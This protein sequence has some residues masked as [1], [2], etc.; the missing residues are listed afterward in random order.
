MAPK[1]TPHSYGNP[2]R[3]QAARYML[4]TTPKILALVHALHE[5]GAGDYATIF[6]AYDSEL[7]G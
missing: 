5:P 4:V 3:S 2:R 7:L 1:G 6:R